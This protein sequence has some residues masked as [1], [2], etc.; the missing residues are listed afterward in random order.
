[1]AVG[2]PAKV[3]FIVYRDSCCCR[4]LSDTST[5]G[6]GW[7]E[8]GELVEELLELAAAAVAE[9]ENLYGDASGGL[10]A[11][12]D[13]LREEGEAVYLEAHLDLIAC[14]AIGSKLRLDKT[15][16]EA[17][18]EDAALPQMPALNAKVDGA[19]TPVARI[20]AAVV[21]I[22]DRLARH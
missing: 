2:A 17:E 18:V 22:V 14:D 7:A 5:F 10:N 11:A 16:I 12:D 21:K 3:Q 4:L 8:E 19:V 15:T 9:E 6:I 13:A 20:A 1:V